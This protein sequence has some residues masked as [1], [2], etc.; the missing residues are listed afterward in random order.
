[1]RTI[2]CIHRMFALL[3]AAA[4][5]AHAGDAARG[6][7]GGTLYRYVRTLQPLGARA[8][9]FQPPGQTP[10]GPVVQWPAPPPGR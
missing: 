3:L 1:M 2:L 9:A 7:D 6:D 10:R 8:P 4:S 5:M